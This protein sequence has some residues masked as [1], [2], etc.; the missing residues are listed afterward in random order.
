MYEQHLVYG[1]SCGSTRGHYRLRH[2][3]HLQERWW[4]L[5]QERWRI[6]HVEK[7]YAP[8][9]SRGG[10]YHFGLRTC[11]KSVPVRTLKGGSH[12][13]GGFPRDAAR[14]RL[15]LARLVPRRARAVHA[16][17][18]GHFRR[19]HRRHLGLCGPMEHSEDFR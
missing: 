17:R 7:T 4:R 10:I 2:Q 16:R 9:G 1:R 12:E 18:L 11:Q 6:K 14:R 5:H 15:P 13:R 3:I 8:G 19:Y